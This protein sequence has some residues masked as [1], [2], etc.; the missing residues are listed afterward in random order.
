MEKFRIHF[1]NT[2]KKL[3]LW[4]K[5]HVDQRYLPSLVGSLKKW[6]KQNSNTFQVMKLWVFLL[7]RGTVHVLD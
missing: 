6:N 4:E 7:S 2:K 3:I 5:K 1:E